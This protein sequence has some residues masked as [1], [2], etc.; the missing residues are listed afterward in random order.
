MKKVINGRKEERGAKKN[1]KEEKENILLRSLSV[2]VTVT[3]TDR[4]PYWSVSVL[5]LKKLVSVSVSVSVKNWYGLTT[6]KK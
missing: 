1:T 2:S 4:D 5:V 3:N 6:L